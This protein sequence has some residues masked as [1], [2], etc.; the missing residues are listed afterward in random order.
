MT[1]DWQMYLG[2]LPFFFSASLALACALTYKAVKKRLARRSPLAS[3]HIGHVPGQ[4]LVKRMSDH[5]TELMT[6]VMIMYMAFP[7][8]FMLWA[9]MQIDWT[10]FQ[11]GTREG[12]LTTGAL[13]CFAYGL[14]EYI[15][16]LHARDRVADGLL[17][18]R[19][20]GMQLNRLVAQGCLVLHDLPADGFN[21][22]HVVVSPRGVYAVETKS[23]RK[24]KRA[25]SE[26]NYNVRFDGKRLHF[27]DFVET[28]AVE[29][30]ERYAHWLEK[31]LREFEINAPVIP[32]LAL[33]GWM[34][35]QPDEIWRSSRVKVFSPMRNGANFMAKDLGQIDAQTRPLIAQALASRYPRIGE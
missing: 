33:P 32:A 27:P 25:K 28:G 17:A 7:M 4:Q 20:T 12:L 35:E 14:W 23:F 3:R 13:A 24:P 10:E 30:A 21:L 2:I 22:D 1:M 6:S 9:G 29:Q 34:I 5:E 8:M 31:T 15:K 19:V 11:W 26:R 16:H 18:E